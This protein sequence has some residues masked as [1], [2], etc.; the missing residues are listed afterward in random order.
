[1][2]G[3]DLSVMDR[4]TLRVAPL[5]LLQYHLALLVSNIRVLLWSHPLLYLLRVPPV[6][7]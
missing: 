4:Y 2:L 7:C 5:L 3:R 1:M 6:L